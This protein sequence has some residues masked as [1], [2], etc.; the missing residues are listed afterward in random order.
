MARQTKPI[1]TNTRS[2]RSLCK[3]GVLKNLAKFTEETL[4]MESLFNKDV[5]LRPSTLLKKT[6]Q[7]RRP[8][9]NYKKFLKT[10]FL[11]NISGQQL[12]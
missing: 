3:I 5:G 4:V 9:V 7:H 12:Q 11:Q 10:T 1:L 2:R 8:S 6:L